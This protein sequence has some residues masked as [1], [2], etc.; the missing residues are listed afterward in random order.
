[1]AHRYKNLLGFF[2]VFLIGFFRFFCGVQ[3]GAYLGLMFVKW[4]LLSVNLRAKRNAEKHRRGG[5]SW[6][7][8]KR[9]DY[10]WKSAHNPEVVGSNPISA[11]M[12][13]SLI[14]L[15][16]RLFLCQKFGWIFGEKTGFGAYL[17]LIALIFAF[18]I[19]YYT[20]LFFSL[21]GALITGT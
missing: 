2:G 12:P 8:L 1:M 3:L 11:T 20:A 4:G 21:P 17:G 10:L 13:K 14:L 16:F 18:F 19:L 5:A 6:H 15:G 9:A 7:F